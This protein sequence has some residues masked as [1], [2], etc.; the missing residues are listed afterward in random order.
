MS[1]FFT[2]DLHF[3]HH[4]IIAHCKRPF[5]GVNEMADGIIANINAVVTPKD[6]LYILGDVAFSDP[7]PLVARIN[8]RKHLIVGNHDEPK[9]SKLHACAF[10]WIKDTYELR[11]DGQKIWLAHY[12]HRAWPGSHR[13]SWHL[14][15]H[16]HG[17]MPPYGKSLDVGVDCW[18]YKP[19]SFETIKARM[20][21]VAENVDHHIR[22]EYV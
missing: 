1:V 13:G 15:G 22:E 21:A 3:G 5:V 18:D 8:G 12:P 14:Y 7:T 10:Q 4:N 20:D 19:V 2:S 16:S 9:K 6:D 11:V 17:G